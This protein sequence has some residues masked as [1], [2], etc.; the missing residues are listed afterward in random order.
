MTRPF[1]AISAECL[2]ERAVSVCP[3]QGTKPVH[4]VLQCIVQEEAWLA[5][6]VL[7]TAA[8]DRLFFHVMVVLN[9]IQQSGVSPYHLGLSNSGV[10][11]AY[12]TKLP[13]FVSMIRNTGKQ[14]GFHTGKAGR[15]FGNCVSASAGTC[16]LLSGYGRQISPTPKTCTTWPISDAR[17]STRSSMHMGF[18][19][20]CLAHDIAF[21]PTPPDRKTGPENPT[22]V[23]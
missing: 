6:S 5:A 16:T 23:V 22:C 4:F 13:R 14:T 17:T 19:S 15:P 11:P 18:G 21:S 9:F 10:R 8:K 3:F 12:P 2:Y 20:R 1:P 7:E